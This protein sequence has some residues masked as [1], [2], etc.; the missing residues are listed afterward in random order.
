MS[1]G[2]APPAHIATDAADA[3][4]P[5]RTRASSLWADAWRRLRRNRA[6]VAAAI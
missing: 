2:I 6:A 3:G 5:R 4:E 1:I